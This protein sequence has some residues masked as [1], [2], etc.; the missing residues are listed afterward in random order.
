MSIGLV[1]N[2]AALDVGS[3]DEAEDIL[4]LTQAA[5]DEAEKME[6]Q[7]TIQLFEDAAA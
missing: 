7:G 2:E 3:Y 5:A 4:C 6:L 1:A